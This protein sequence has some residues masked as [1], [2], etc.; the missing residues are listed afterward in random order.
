VLSSSAVH[1]REITRL[2]ECTWGD[3]LLKSATRESGECEDKLVCKKFMCP[4]VV[5][6][7]RCGVDYYHAE[8]SHR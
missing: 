3:Q 8:Q 5:Q 7:Q 1:R 6:V 2:G 4:V